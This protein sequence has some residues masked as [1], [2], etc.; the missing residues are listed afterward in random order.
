M[1]DGVCYTNGSYFEN[2]LMKTADL[3]CGHSDEGGGQ[4][5]YPNGTTCTSTSSPIQCTDDDG[6]TIVL[7]R[8]SVTFDI[9]HELGYKCCLPHTCSC[10]NPSTDMIIANIYSK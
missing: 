7:R 10:N 1:Y 2:T 9:G 3:I 6:N 5:L 4:L 8:V